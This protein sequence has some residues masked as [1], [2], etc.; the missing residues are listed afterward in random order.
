MK[1]LYHNSSTEIKNFDDSR[2]I[3]FTSELSEAER[4]TDCNNGEAKYLYKIEIESFE[5]TNDFMAFHTGE[6]LNNSKSGIVKMTS[7]DIDNNWYVIKNINKFNPSQ[8]TILTESIKNQIA[9]TNGAIAESDA[10][11]EYI[12][13]TID[14]SNKILK[15]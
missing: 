5:E 12:Q 1:T 15:R 9:K 11:L 4:Y 6:I 13:M 14:E 8:T 3:W 2:P 7:E 10:R